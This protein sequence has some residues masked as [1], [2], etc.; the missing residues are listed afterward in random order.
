MIFSNSFKT[1]Q[2]ERPLGE[3]QNVNSYDFFIRTDLALQKERRW[4]QFFV[5]EQLFCN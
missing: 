3:R 4:V 5:W 2:R 1:W